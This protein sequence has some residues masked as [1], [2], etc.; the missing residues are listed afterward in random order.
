VR[1]E[2]NPAQRPLLSL[3]GV[4]AAVGVGASA[5]RHLGWWLEWQVRA[6]PGE[7]CRE[8]RE[9]QPLPSVLSAE[10]AA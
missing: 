8:L 4:A 5:V 2:G 1:G 3:A 10:S 7:G 6:K 9:E